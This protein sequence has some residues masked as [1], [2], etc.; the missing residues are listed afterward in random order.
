MVGKK[1]VRWRN[2]RGGGF[3][4][5]EVL[6]ALL[7]VSIVL[8]VAMKGVAA[9]TATATTAKRRNEAAPL[10]QSKLDEILATQAWSTGGMSGDFGPDWSDYTWSAELVQWSPNGMNM[11]NG[12]ASTSGI[13]TS[14]PS[15]SSSVPSG[16]VSNGTQNTTGTPIANATP[17]NN[18]LQELD[19]HVMW[20]GRTGQESLTLSTL[21]YKSGNV[22]TSGSTN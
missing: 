12:L 10:A 19:V 21:V 18:T 16:T 2:Q 11:S 20:K 5:I 22:S 15:G 3:T 8:P 14:T 1:V 4:L 9:A 7:L 13:G 17:T 6:A